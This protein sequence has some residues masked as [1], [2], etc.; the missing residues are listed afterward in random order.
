MYGA[1]TLLG[2]LIFG[3]LIEKFTS[4]GGCSSQK[5]LGRLRDAECA[6]P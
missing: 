6:E 2:A 3:W 5:C 1:G 4:E